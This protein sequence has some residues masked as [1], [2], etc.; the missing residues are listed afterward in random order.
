MHH[1]I[2]F[3]LKNLQAPH[4]EPVPGM[5]FL[6]TFEFLGLGVVV[7]FLAEV[8]RDTQIK[9]GGK[10]ELLDSLEKKI[11]IRIK[12]TDANDLGLTVKLIERDIRDI[13]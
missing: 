7:R 8:W 13:E 10:G 4:G 5:A 1:W 9:S 6:G 11:L 12:A 3:F 2:H